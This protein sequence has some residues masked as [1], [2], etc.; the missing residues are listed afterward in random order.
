[1]PAYLG[2][3]PENEQGTYQIRMANLNENLAIAAY[4]F[5]KCWQIFYEEV[6]MPQLNVVDYWWRF[7]WQHRGSSHI[8]GF[9]WLREAPSVDDLGLDDDQSVYQFV[10]FWDQLVLTRNPKPTHPP[11][12]IHLSSQPFT[13]LSGT[14]QE[15]AELINCVQRHVKCSSYCLHHNKTTREEVCGFCFP[16]DLHDLT[17][18]VQREGESLPEFFPKRNDPLLNSCNQTWLLGW[19]AN[20]DFWPILSPHAAISYI[21]KYVS[22]AESHSKIYQ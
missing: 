7:E 22:K 1:M 17:E 4:Y 9:L 5:Q 21:S 15:L 10:T 6:V 12:P 13:T 14:Q 2:A 19:H 20:M 18:L 8:H 11:A 3:L 16:Q